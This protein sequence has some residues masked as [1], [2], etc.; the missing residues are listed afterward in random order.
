M[1][2][3]FE[4]RN[5]NDACNA[6]KQ[7]KLVNSRIYHLHIFVNNVTIVYGHFHDIVAVL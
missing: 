4:E 1:C 6:T 7:A 2:A 3:K 5:E